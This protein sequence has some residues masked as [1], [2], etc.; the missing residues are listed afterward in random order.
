MNF[1]KQIKGKIEFWK[2]GI[3]LFI[4]SPTHNKPLINNGNTNELFIYREFCSL[5]E[6]KNYDFSESQY[7]DYKNRFLKGEIFCVLE[8]NNQIA[9]FGWVNPNLGH[10]IGELALQIKENIKAE[11]LYNFETISIHRGKGLYPYLLNRICGRND[12]KKIIYALVENAASIKGIKKAGF[13]H[14]GNIYGFNKNKIHDLLIN[15]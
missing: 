15:I 4:F 8:I 10:R 6:I 7:L 12:K 2:R 1:I 5:D 11:V 3:S 9:S 13:H 14:L